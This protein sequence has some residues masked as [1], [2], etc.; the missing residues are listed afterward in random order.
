MKTSP[1]SI[2]FFSHPSLYARVIQEPDACVVSLSA[3]PSER[4]SAFY[5]KIWKR[6]HNCTS[7]KGACQV[8][9]G[10]VRIRR[11][12]T[13]AHPVLLSREHFMAIGNTR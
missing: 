3:R 1:C 4:S 2:F 13:H 12:A 8:S 6:Y 7:L 11:N 10:S 5:D 9:H